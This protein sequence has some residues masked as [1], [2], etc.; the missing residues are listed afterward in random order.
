MK[1]IV[2]EKSISTENVSF[3][4]GFSGWANAGEVSTGSTNYLQKHLR[5]VKIGK[6]L[7]DPFYTLTTKR[8]ITVIENGYLKKVTTL[9]NEI[10]F[11]KRTSS[12]KDL[13]IMAGEEPHLKWDEYARSL[14]EL[15]Q[16]YQAKDIYLIG[17]T[18]DNILHSAEP[19]LSTV[20]NDENMRAN[21]AIHGIE[22][23]SYTGPCSIHTLISQ[24]AIGA[25]IPTMSLWCHV[26]PYLSN[27]PKAS[28]KILTTLE[29]LLGIECDARALKTSAEAIDKQIDTLIAQNPTLEKYI[30]ELKR[31]GKAPQ[32]I[33]RLTEFDKVISIDAFLKKGK[34]DSDHP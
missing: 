19:K 18:Y 23:I 11:V 30:N 14:I 24:A 12:Q 7:T 16:Y 8:P 1:N 3:I 10:F 27:N 22:L 21:A 6:I 29:A 2:I 13:L 15:A 4:I 34:K 9:E 5:A 17:G 32:E 31:E 28:Y 20:T 25:G 33:S 26:P